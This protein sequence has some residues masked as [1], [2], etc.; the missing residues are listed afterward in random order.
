MTWTS[1]ED[2]KLHNV[3]ILSKAAGVSAQLI[4]ADDMFLPIRGLQ[5]NGESKWHCFE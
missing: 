3:D 1:K 4:A 2:C 5:S